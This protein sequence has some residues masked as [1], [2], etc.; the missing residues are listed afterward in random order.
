MHKYEQGVVYSTPPMHA[1]FFTSGFGEISSSPILVETPT[2]SG[3]S[4]LIANTK[5]GQ[6]RAK[7]TPTDMIEICTV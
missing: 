6:I 4:K 7:L 3:T 2:E 1:R 5:S